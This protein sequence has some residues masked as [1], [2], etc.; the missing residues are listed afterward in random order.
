MYVYPIYAHLLDLCIAVWRTVRGHPL[1]APLIIFALSPKPVSGYMYTCSTRSRGRSPWR[2]DGCTGGGFFHIRAETYWRSKSFLSWAYTVSVPDN[3]CQ[4]T[5]ARQPQILSPMWSHLPWYNGSLWTSLFTPTLILSVT[6]TVGP[7]IKASAIDPM[8]DDTNP[9]S[10]RVTHP[11]RLAHGTNVSMT[12][13][14]SITSRTWVALP[15]VK[16][17]TLDPLWIEWDERPSRSRIEQLTNFV[18]M[19]D[20]GNG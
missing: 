18:E 6:F 1:H 10:R 20:G 12:S 11:I 3:Q 16:W 15:V 9:V 4:T 8:V 19:N 2:M 13:R 14:T 5:K 7:G 17:S